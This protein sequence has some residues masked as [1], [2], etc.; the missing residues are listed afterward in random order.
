MKKHKKIL[1]SLTALTILLS[2]VSGCAESKR[3]AGT[4]VSEERILV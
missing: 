3:T 1:A 2:L 4:A